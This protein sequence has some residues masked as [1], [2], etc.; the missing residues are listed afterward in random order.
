MRLEKYITRIDENTDEELLAYFLS[1]VKDYLKE[2]D[3]VRLWR[4]HNHNIKGI[5]KFSARKNRKPRDTP[6][7]VHDFLDKWFKSNFGWKARS[8]G[9]FCSTTPS[10][11]EPFGKNVDLFFPCNGYKYVWSNII[12]DMTVWLEDNGYIEATGRGKWEATGFNHG[13]MKMTLMKTLKQEYTNK[14]LPQASYAST[15]VMMYCPN[16]YYQIDGDFFKKFYREI[17]PTK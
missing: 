12:Q 7:E 16:G 5:Q 11:I 1:E 17:Y 13:G 2:Q 10:N 14:N 4:A 15:E 9:V 3:G 8:E 6:K